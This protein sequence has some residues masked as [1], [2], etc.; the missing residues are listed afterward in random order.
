MGKQSRRKRERSPGEAR[1]TRYLAR[2]GLPDR[3]DPGRWRRLVAA[4][5]EWFRRVREADEAA[6]ALSRG[7]GPGLGE[8]DRADVLAADRVRYSLVYRDLETALAEYAT[9][10]VMIAA[11][12][13]RWWFEH[14]PAA[15]RLVDV[16]CGP[17]VLT[18]AYALAQPEAEVVGIDAVPE[19]LAC[20]EELAKRLGA[21]NVSFV[22]GDAVDPAVGG[23]GFDQLVAVTALADAG[24]Y[25][26]DPPDARQ[27]LSSVADVDGPGLGFRSAGIEALVG[28][29][30]PGGS[31]L[32]FD[33]TPDASQAVRFGAALL[34]AGV[35]LD[36]RRAGVEIFVEEDRATTFTRFAGVR[37]GPAAEA[38]GTPAAAGA[39]LAA[40]LKGV[41]APAYGPEWHDELRFE[42]LKSAGARLVWGCEIDYTPRSPARER[43]EVWENGGAW[44]WIATTPRHREL[45]S[46]R[47]ADELI[48]EYHTLAA[49]LAAAGFAVRYY[50]D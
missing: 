12:W 45:V 16:G 48:R 50:D 19:A 5:P 7:A 29:V 33:R 24:L 1:A 25:P 37:S 8:V 41:R 3:P 39:A 14:Q 9:R 4:D 13:L 32:A 10:P 47:R 23:G 34:H 26:H 35:E 2:A 40:W 38:A 17:G 31:V 28:R 49:R 44:G 30:A 27:A 20:A 18:C 43:R 6:L 11:A 15:G 46:G 22:E 42:A 21:G 36:L